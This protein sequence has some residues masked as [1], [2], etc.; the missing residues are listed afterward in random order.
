MNVV[1]IVLAYNG[2]RF[3]REC[4]ASLAALPPGFQVLVVDNGSADE[5]LVIAR[6]FAPAVA[7]VANGANLGFSGGMNRGMRLALGFERAPGLELAPAD[8]VVLLNQDTRVLPGWAEAIVAPLADSS[9]AAVG[10]KLLAGDERTILHVGGVVE[11]PRAITRHLGAGEPDAGQYREL[12]D[13]E[14]ATGAALALRADALRQVGMF[15][16][17]FNP[18]YMEEVDLCA[19]LRR[20]GQRVVVNPAAAAVHYEGSSTSDP[21]PRLFWVQCNRLLYLAKHADLAELLGPF[22]EAERADIRALQDTALLRLL[23][24]VYARS[25]INL[26]DWCAARAADGGQPFT[27]REQRQIL[28]TWA[29]LRDECVRQDAYMLGDIAILP[30]S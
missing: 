21:M 20:A 24:R 8:A 30:E 11:H 4:L 17:R 12:L 25:L 16:E 3:L 27:R 13:V 29:A 26:P 6:S 10:C 14:Y 5:S 18:A 15:D 9:V 2:A 23:K 19:R 22:A 7:V 1:V 28:H